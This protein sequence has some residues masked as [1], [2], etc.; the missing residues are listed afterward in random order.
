MFQKRC[1]N[2]A[3]IAGTT[4]RLPCSPVN[5]K[6]LQLQPGLCSLN[7]RPSPIDS[8]RFL[9]ACRFGHA[10]LRHFFLDAGT[11]YFAQFFLGFLLHRTPVMIARPKRYSLIAN[12]ADNPGQ[13][14]PYLGRASRPRVPAK[15]KAQA[16]AIEIDRT[17][18]ARITLSR[19]TEVLQAARG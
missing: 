5:R 19:R 17:W 7:W 12:A 2:A 10:R 18:P 8:V 16:H 3:S 1:L 6:R 13:T 4:R 9:L 11:R 14:P 15:V